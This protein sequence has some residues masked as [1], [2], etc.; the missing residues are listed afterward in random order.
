[1]GGGI[2]V[3]GNLRLFDSKLLGNR[4]TVGGGVAVGGRLLILRSLIVSN[5][6]DNNGV[7]SHTQD[8]ERYDRDRFDAHRQ[9]GIDWWRD[10]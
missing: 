10:P 6:A 8:F 3:G 1:M 4:V 5:I 9:F 7:R 2:F